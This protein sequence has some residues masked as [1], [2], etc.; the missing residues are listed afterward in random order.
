MSSSVINFLRHWFCWA[1][2]CPVIG[3][4]SNGTRTP[5]T[6]A[7]L[8][9]LNQ[10][11]DFTAVCAGM[12]QAIKLPW[13]SKLVCE[14]FNRGWAYRKQRSMWC[15]ADST[16]EEKRHLSQLETAPPTLDW[17]TMNCLYNSSA[18]SLC[19]HFISS[20]TDVRFGLENG[21]FVVIWHL[22]Q[23]VFC[24]KSWMHARNM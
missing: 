16:G 3:Q 13:M 7:C 17:I 5:H 10:R 21:I 11:S 4:H 18:G 22:E 2:K 19:A 20:R 12:L 23:T 9:G 1:N 6:A 14:I 8:L 24:S 15:S